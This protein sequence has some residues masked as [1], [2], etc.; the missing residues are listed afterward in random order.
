M[1]TEMEKKMMEQLG[2]GQTSGDAAGGVEL[3]PV[4]F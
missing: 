2:V 3:P 1:T 4:D